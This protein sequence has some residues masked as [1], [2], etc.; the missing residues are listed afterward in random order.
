MGLLFSVWLCAW[1]PGAPPDSVGSVL[2][3]PAYS[4]A[5]VLLGPAEP[6][7]PQPGDL[8]FATD[9]SALVRFFH[10]VALAAT[11]HHSGIVFARPDGSL[12]LLEAGPHHT[13][14]VGGRDLLPEL[15]SYEAEAVV[16]IRRRRRPLSPEQSARL[17][18]F[19]LAQEGKRFA[20]WRVMGQL[21]PF[22]SRGPLRT[23]VVG[24]P[25]GDRRRYF[26]A[27]LVVEAL[28][29]SGLLPAGEARP[30]A[31]YPRDLFFGRSPNPWLARHLDLSPG[32]LPPAR[33]ASDRA[34]PA[35][36]GQRHPGP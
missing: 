23:F 3:R 14:D 7:R 17:T 31:T 34:A 8:F 15:C 1:P 33:W 32:W 2:Y 11:P 6:Y 24:K 30:S 4:A 29:A 10:R 5:D 25:R 28:V 12:A 18:A 21:T 20:W 27:E 19:A 22:R 16:W 36:G 13:L 9:P 26:C 35:C